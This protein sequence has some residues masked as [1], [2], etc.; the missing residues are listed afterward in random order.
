M[1]NKLVSILIPV[2][3]RE[4]YI[5][6]TIKSAL[7]QT[8]KNIEIIVVDNHSTDDT[9]KKLQEIVLIDSRIKIFQNEHNIGPV[10]NWKRCIDEASGEYGK[11]LF[12][13]DL[14]DSKF[15]DKTINYLDNDLVGFVFTGREIFEDNEEKTP[16]VY[17][18]IGQTD[19]YSSQKYINGVFF[20][21]NYP[22]SPGCA[23]FRLKDLKENLLIDVPNKINSDFAMHGINILNHSF[24]I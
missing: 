24:K 8:Y 21:K 15:I 19:T 18:T 6:E 17:M 22:N 5:E 9:W 7:A 2:Y 10:K 23:L 20:E 4:K 3:N 16:L 14:M 1:N 12:S 11:V 13:D